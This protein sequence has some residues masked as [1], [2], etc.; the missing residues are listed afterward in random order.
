MLISFVDS[1]IFGTQRK[2]IV[3]FLLVVLCIIF[4][5]EATSPFSETTKASTPYRYWW[6]CLHC[7]FDV[8]IFPWSVLTVVNQHNTCGGNKHFPLTI[9][10]T[11]GFPEGTLNGGLLLLGLSSPPE[12]V[13]GYSFPVPL[14]LFIYFQQGI[15]KNTLQG[16]AFKYRYQ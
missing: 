3:I 4:I 8:V 1:H 2:L 13:W 9:C 7:L 14:S 15:K 12:D 10:K 11:R 5:T 16:D 6:N